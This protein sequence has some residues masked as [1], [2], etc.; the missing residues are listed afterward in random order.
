MMR[1]ALP[2]APEGVA[3]ST[4]AMS[5]PFDPVALWLQVRALPFFDRPVTGGGYGYPRL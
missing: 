5:D 3:V 1:H 2:G 4:V